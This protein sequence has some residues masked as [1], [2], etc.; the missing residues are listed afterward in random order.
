MKLKSSFLISI[1]I[2]ELG[3]AVYMTTAYPTITWWD[4]SQYSTAAV[5]LGITGAPGSLI[6]TLLGKS[7]SKIYPQN[8][9]FIFNITA[10]FLGTLA[11]L[12]C[13]HC[14]KKIHSIVTGEKHIKFYIIESISLILTGG[15]I[16]CSA[17]LWEYALMFT[18]YILTA[19]FTAFIFMSVLHWWMR[20]ND[21]DSWKSIFLIAFLIGIDFSVHRT[22]ALF[23]PGIIVVM[24]IKNPKTFLTRKS[25]ISAFF[26]ILLGLSLQLLYIPIS[27]NN[28]PL[29]LGETNN[30]FTL[31]N[32]ISLKQ[33]GGNFLMDI[34][35]RKGPLWS[36]QIPYYI[37]GFT[38]NF[39]YPSPSTYNLGYLPGVLGLL[40]II[41]ILRSDIKLGISMIFL[42]II[43]IITSILYFNLPENYFRPIYR[44]YLP[45]YI[46]FSIFIFAGT[47]FIFEMIKNIKEKYQWIPMLLITVLIAGSLLTQYFTNAENNNGSG[48]YFTYNHASNIINSIDRD[49]ILF[50]NGDNNY[51]PE[52]YL[53]IG[54][55][56]RPNIIQCNIDLLNLDWYIKQHQKNN[57]SFPF[58][59]KGVN[60]TEVKQDNWKTD[61][62]DIS[63]TDSIK[64]KY[65]SESDTFHL[66]LPALRENSYNLLQDVV[67][68]DIFK[69]NKWTKPI[70]FTKWGLDPKLY[71][72]LKPYLRDEGLVYKFVPDSS[73]EI[74]YSKIQSNLTK[75]KI[76]G[77]N[78]SSIKL[79]DVSRNVGILYYDIFLNLSKWKIKTGDL[80]ASADL[81]EQMKSVLPFDRLKPDEKI[82]EETKAIGNFLKNPKPKN[83]RLFAD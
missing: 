79:D 28:P 60:T 2:L 30:L 31:W 82:L 9:A 81:L 83:R 23:I 51:F 14:S 5:C 66:S 43:T 71:S 41:S 74:D 59:G 26:G 77:Y 39:F 69:N 50:S 29:N 6:L 45:T 1:T 35:V 20:A 17:T 13:F 78:D 54:E 76:L 58:I 63:I 34:L 64:T 48:H 37:D 61:S 44:H 52:L 40:G 16:I 19:L 65:T 68:F 25:Y 73:N 80:K 47:F 53:Q 56:Q 70:Y 67:L 62:F 11:V 46:I 22:N 12:Y 38:R 42:F 3:C 7:I 75:F 21:P 24:M 55:H 8:P 27:M 49:G 33:Y 18:P 32:F 36:Y 15:I 10:G 72:W 57:K 4:S